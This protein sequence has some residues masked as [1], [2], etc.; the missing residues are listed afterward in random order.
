MAS[1][2][3]AAGADVEDSAATLRRT[4]VQLDLYLTYL[5]RVFHTCYYSG[6]I[7]DSREEL[8]SRSLKYLRKVPVAPAPVPVEAPATEEPDAAASAEVKTTPEVDEAVPEADD[9]ADADVPMEDEETDTPRRRDD[10]EP[11][12]APK[13]KSAEQH[14]ADNAV[15]SKL[16]D[17]VSRP[18]TPPSKPR[19]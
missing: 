1:L 15:A 12:S 5:R 8:E 9:A 6:S 14:K 17:R 19:G 18:A 2:A 11:A 7:N 16:S 10:D 4:K 3:P 13:A